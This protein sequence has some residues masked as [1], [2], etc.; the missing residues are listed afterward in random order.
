MPAGLRMGEML[1]LHF[2]SYIY[3]FLEVFAGIERLPACYTQR[4]NHHTTLMKGKLAGS[5]LG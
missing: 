1:L 3:F 2:L 4:R 5:S